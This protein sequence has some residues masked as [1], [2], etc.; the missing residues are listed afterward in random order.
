VKEK[1]IRKAL[2]NIKAI[3]LDSYNTGIPESSIDLVILIDAIQSIKDTDAF[4][5]KIHQLRKTGSWLFMEAGHLTIPRARDF[6]LSTGFFHH[7]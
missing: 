7:G 4:F 1:A 5:H 2:T 6:V 3:L